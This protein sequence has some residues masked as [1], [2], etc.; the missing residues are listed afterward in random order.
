MLVKIIRWLFGCVR[1]HLTDGFPERFVNLAVRNKIS[2]RNMRKLKNGI[3]GEVVAKE[4]F[5][6]RKLAK[7]CGCKIKIAEKFGFP[8]KTKKYK[9]RKGIFVGL[10]LFGMILYAFSSYIW[11]VDVSGNSN[12]SSE[13][14]LEVMN[15]LGIFGGSLK[16]RIN[17]PM[18]RQEAMLKLPEIAWISVNIKGS[19]ADILIKEKIKAPELAHESAPCDI[20]AVCD[21]KI[22]RIETYKGTP[23]VRSGD[24][25]LKGQLLISGI[26]EDLSGA[27]SFV[28]S[29]GK[30]YAYTRRTIEESIKLSQ[31]KAMDTGKIKKKYRIKIFGLEIPFGLWGKTKET[32]RCEF[33]SDKLH[34]GKMDLPIIFYRED[35]YEQFYDIV[36]LTYEEALDEAKRLISEREKNELGDKKILNASFE[37]K[38]EDGICL[39]SAVYDC[40]EDIGIKEEIKLSLSEK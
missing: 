16:K 4:Y 11:S 21:G 19:H 18:V 40:L 6:L 33:Y 35:R 9:K 32:D 2:M 17:I 13:K 34:I 20:K 14:I 31:E 27:S 5:L 12:I 37:D 1:F 30:V 23:A 38:E 10:L 22:D 36:N 15:E 28:H 8:F 39:A 29:D 25:V 7:N 24:A 26:V 3:E